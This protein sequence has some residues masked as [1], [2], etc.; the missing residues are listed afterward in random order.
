MKRLKTPG[1]AAL[2]V[3]ALA[4]LIDVSS[5]AALEFHGPAGG[6]LTGE[7]TTSH[8]FEITGQKFTCN[9]HF[10]G[11]AA[12]SG[13]SETQSL[14]PEYPND[15]TGFGLPATI[16]TD[17]C[18]FNFNANLNTVNLTS[19]T[20]GAITIDSSNAFSHCHVDIPNQNGINGQSFSNMGS[21]ADNATLTWTTA[22]TNLTAT[23]TIDDGLCPLLKGHHNDAKYNG[24]TGIMGP[25]SSPQTHIN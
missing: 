11:T 15:C 17:G 5:A 23:V 16:N 19:C 18:L 14:H 2:A 8:I 22:A 10:N 21:T 4:A 6:A 12:A 7:G 9:A 3:V 20:N 25:A 1:L 24:V 13:T